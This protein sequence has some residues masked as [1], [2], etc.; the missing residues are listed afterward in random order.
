MSKSMMTVDEVA[1]E[2]AV[3]KAKAYLIIR[4]LNR[5]LEKKNYITIAGKIPRKYLATKIFGGIGIE[6]EVIENV[7]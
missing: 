6:S 7:V 4:Q 1:E 5:E 2:L 3:S